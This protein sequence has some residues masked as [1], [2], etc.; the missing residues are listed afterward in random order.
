MSFKLNEV[1]TFSTES[2]PPSQEGSPRTM[3]DMPASLIERRCGYVEQIWGK[4]Q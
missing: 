2:C 1:V 4:P 3:A